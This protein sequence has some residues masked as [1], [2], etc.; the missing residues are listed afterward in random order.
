M[1]LSLFH[2]KFQDFFNQYLKWFYSQMNNLLLKLLDI[3]F[4]FY[5][6]G[7]I[8]YK[9]TNPETFREISLTALE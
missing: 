3:T 4:L 6:W 2:E 7:F 1:L 8:N 5:P 9:L